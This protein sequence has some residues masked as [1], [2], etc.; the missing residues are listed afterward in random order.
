MK[1]A[2]SKPFEIPLTK[3][4]ESQTISLNKLRSMTLPINSGVLKLNQM[5]IHQLR[6]L[7]VLKRR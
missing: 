4:R 3:R 1:M 6:R 2:R 5:P 7:K